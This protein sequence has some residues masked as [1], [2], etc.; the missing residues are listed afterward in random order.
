MVS[1]HRRLAEDVAVFKANPAQTLGPS[2]NCRSHEDQNG[3]TTYVACG[4]GSS[5]TYFAGDKRAWFGFGF[6][7]VLTLTLASLPLLRAR[8]RPLA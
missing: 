8:R 2:F 5:T 3:Q 7:A 6:V 1:D 4:S